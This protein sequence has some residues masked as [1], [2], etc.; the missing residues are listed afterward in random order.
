MKKYV[1]NINIGNIALEFIDER[2]QSEGH[3]GIHLSQHN[4]Y[5][6]TKL[7]EILTLLNK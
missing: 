2:L 1:S 4:R 6:L 3:H 7:T 5:D